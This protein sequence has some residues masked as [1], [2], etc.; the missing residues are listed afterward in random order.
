MIILQAL[1]NAVDPVKAALPEGSVIAKYLIKIACH[2]VTQVD[3]L[4]A[5]RKKRKYVI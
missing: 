2:L 4:K 3:R 1:D 5:V